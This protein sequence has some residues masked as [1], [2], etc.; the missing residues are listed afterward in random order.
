MKRRYF[1]KITLFF[2][3]IILGVCDAI[4]PNIT[5]SIINVRFCPIKNKNEYEINYLRLLSCFI[6]F[7][8]LILHFTKFLILY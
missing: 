1:V 4:F 6:A 2:S 5:N 3:S 8:L 7:T